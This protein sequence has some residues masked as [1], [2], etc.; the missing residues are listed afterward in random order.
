VLEALDYKTGKVQ[1]S[2]PYPALSVSGGL[3]GPGILSTAGNLLFSGD[4]SGNLIG[5]DAATGKILWH[6]PMLHSL[7]NGPITFLLDGKQYLVV[8]AGDTLY[9]FARLPN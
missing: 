7:A 8:G 6:F 1:W 4:Y 5:Y 2:H 3:G 9:A